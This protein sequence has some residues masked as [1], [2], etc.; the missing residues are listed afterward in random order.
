M[1]KVFCF[2]LFFVFVLC[3]TASAEWVRGHWKDTNRDGFKDTYVDSYQRSPRN[4]T[5]TDNY[6][7]PG[8]YNP[9]TGRTSG[10]KYQW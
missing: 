8:N 4:S 5:Q 10:G 7:Y 6:S 3:S 9:N 1:K 2:A